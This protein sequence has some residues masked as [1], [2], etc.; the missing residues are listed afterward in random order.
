[1]GDTKSSDEKIQCFC[2]EIFQR[3][4][5]FNIALNKVLRIEKEYFVFTLDAENPLDQNSKILP[6]YFPMFYNNSTSPT[7]FQAGPNLAWTQIFTKDL[8]SRLLTYSQNEI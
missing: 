5:P 8:K 7:R 1:M 6:R 4:A 2:I 3:K